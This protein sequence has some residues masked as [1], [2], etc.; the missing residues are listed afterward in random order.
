VLE[1]RKFLLAAFACGLAVLLIVAGGIAYSNI[2]LSLQDVKVQH[3]VGD[4]QSNI[5]YTQTAAEILPQSPSNI[6]ETACHNLYS[7]TPIIFEGNCTYELVTPGL[8]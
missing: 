2:P 4:L 8:Y 1:D 3:Q 5:N 6:L 7:S